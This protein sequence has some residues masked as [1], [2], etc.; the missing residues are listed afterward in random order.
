MLACL[1][2]QVQSRFSGD[3]KRVTTKTRS[4]GLSVQKPFQ[5]CTI[6][7][8]VGER[9]GDMTEHH[10]VGINQSSSSLQIKP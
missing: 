5:L 2:A 10:H 6:S 8:S 1:F 3:P 4:G 9:T 7:P